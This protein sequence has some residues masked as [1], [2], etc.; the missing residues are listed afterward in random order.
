VEESNQIGVRE[1]AAVA[2]QVLFG[3]ASR[4]IQLEEPKSG[5]Q[6]IKIKGRKK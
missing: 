6:D 3:S 5:S 2:V 4:L 1:H